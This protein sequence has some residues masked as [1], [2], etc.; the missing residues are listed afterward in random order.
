MST[1]SVQVSEMLPV[2]FQQFLTE[3]KSAGCPFGS[4]LQFSR[5]PRDEPLL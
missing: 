3:T 4:F 2:P 5:S 1:L